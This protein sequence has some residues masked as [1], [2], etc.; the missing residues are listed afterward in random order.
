MPTIKHN[1]LSFA[2]IVLMLIFAMPGMTDLFT[3]VY[4]TS[5]ISDILDSLLDALPFFGDADP[6]PNQPSSSSSP[7]SPPQSPRAP[8]LTADSPAGCSQSKISSIKASGYDGDNVP[9]NTVDKN[10]NTRWADNGIGSFIQ[11]KLESSDIICRIDIAWH[12]GDVRTSDFTVSVSKDGSKFVKVLSSESSGETIYLERYII[13]DSALAA[14]Y[15]RITVNGNTENDWASITEVRIL[16]QSSPP[17][18]NHTLVYD[19]TSS[20][21]RTILPIQMKL[22]DGTWSQPVKYNFDTGASLP[23]DVAPEFLSA[24]GYG[25]DGVGSDPSKRITL[26]GKIKIV[27]LD[28]EFDLPVMVQDK[29][30]YDLFRDQPPPIRYPLLRVADILTEVSMVFTNEE[31]TI[32]LRDVPIPEL[33][34]ISK[35]ISLPDLQRRDGTP[36]SGYQWMRVDFINPSTGGAIEDWFGL[37][38]GDDKLV[39]KKQSVAD[40]LQLPLTRTSSCNYDSESTIVFKEAS[41]PAKLDSAPVQVREETCQFARG[42]EPRNFGGGP[43][44]LSEYTLILWDMHRALL[45]V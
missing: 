37:N 39:L 9:K 19:L 33:A 8:S 43:A 16:S 41:K 3:K 34:D 23:T 27:G 12:K 20:E 22:P 30:H 14:K 25:P 18:G 15:V 29:A 4:A 6:L 24:F 32:R 28:G 26:P 10:Y 5:S 40:V 17:S 42:G 31:T 36:T 38:T 21:T 11:Y 1:R 2:S 45:P 13:P 35:L 44:F 7:S